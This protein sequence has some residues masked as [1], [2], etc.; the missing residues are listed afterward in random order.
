MKARKDIFWVSVLTLLCIACFPVNPLVLSG[1]LEIKTYTVTGIVAWIVWGFGMILVLYPII[2]F[3]R[4][5]G[6]RKGLSF[7]KTTRLVDTGL[8]AVIRHPQ[9]TGGIYAIFLA[10]FLA[11]PHWLFGVMG[12]AGIVLVYQ[13]IA[14]EDRR[15]V[16]KF[17]EAYVEYMKK[18]PAMNFIAGTY[19]LLRKR[20][21]S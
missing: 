12:I 16:E 9:Y 5:G 1:A 18:V 2:M 21:I 11:Y 4:S 3:P 14:A 20:R 17:G 7:V 6:A 10:T 15:L 13:S 19:R 8:Y